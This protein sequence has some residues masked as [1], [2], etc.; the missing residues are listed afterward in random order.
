MAYLLKASIATS[1]NCSATRTPGHTVLQDA[2]DQVLNCHGLPRLLLL[3]VVVGQSGL[4][5]R[6]QKP[7]N[8]KSNGGQAPVTKAK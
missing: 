1:R 4:A 3:L 6:K 8:S 5:C 7:S 2:T